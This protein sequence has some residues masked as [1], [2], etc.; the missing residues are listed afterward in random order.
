MT[1]ALCMGMLHFADQSLYISRALS[2]S[3]QHLRALLSVIT[4]CEGAGIR[5]DVNKGNI[6][7]RGSGARHISHGLSA[8]TCR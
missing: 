4:R 8:D 1:T 6:G 3:N 5:G 7:E 2:S